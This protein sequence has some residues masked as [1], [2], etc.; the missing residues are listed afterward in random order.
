MSSLETSNVMGIG[1]SVPSASR[2]VST[3]L[4]RPPIKVRTGDLIR[5]DNRPVIVFLN[6]E[7]LQGAESS[8]HY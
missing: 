1:N 5:C 6:H 4:H 8:I 2:S 7:S 3:T